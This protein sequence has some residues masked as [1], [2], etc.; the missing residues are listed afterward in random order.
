MKK[1]I[2][3]A[4]FACGAFVSVNAFAV[5]IPADGVVRTADCTL[6]GESVTLS[7]SN[8][9]SGAY[10]CDEITS[11][12]KVGACH[13]AG[14]RKAMTV[15]CAITVPADGETPAEYNDDSCTGVGEDHTFESS[16][17]RGYVA[18]SRGGSTAAKDLGGACTAA[19]ADGLL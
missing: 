2:L 14:S 10:S 12:I 17:Y 9:V 15:K 3:A 8:N 13:K 4:L 5:A 1:N 6:L 19:T 18:S 7:L 11:T 16:N